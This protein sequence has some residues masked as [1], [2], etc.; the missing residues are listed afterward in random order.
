MTNDYKKIMPHNAVLVCIVL[1]NVEMRRPVFHMKI[2]CFVTPMVLP[3]RG[4]VVENRLQLNLP[5]YCET[6]DS[7]LTEYHYPSVNLIR[8][9][10]EF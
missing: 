5:H 10:D 9:N 8:S 7:I 1:R 6:R 4:L 3:R 2:K